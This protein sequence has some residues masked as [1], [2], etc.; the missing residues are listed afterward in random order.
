MRHAFINSVKSLEQAHLCHALLTAEQPQQILCTGTAATCGLSMST[1]H[2]R[3]DRKM[4]PKLLFLEF[5]SYPELLNSSD[6]HLEKWCDYSCSI[7][8]LSRFFWEGK[9]SNWVVLYIYIY[10]SLCTY[11]TE[12]SNCICLAQVGKKNPVVSHFSIILASTYRCV[13]G[14][15]R[16]MLLWC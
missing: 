4:L 15:K 7:R 8:L 16:G 5:W 10:V 11:P 2:T 12:M 9:C 1:L 3:A 14:E 6:G 13:S